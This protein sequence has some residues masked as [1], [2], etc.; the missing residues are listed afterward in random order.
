MA[1]QSYIMQ[2]PASAVRQMIFDYTIKSFWSKGEEVIY[3]SQKKYI[4]QFFWCL[5]LVKWNAL[6]TSWYLL[7]PGF[8]VQVLNTLL[9]ALCSSIFEGIILSSNLCHSIND[10]IRVIDLNKICAREKSANIMWVD[11]NGLYI[12]KQFF[13]CVK[14]F[15]TILKWR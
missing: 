8:S 12:L 11:R 3:W 4:L 10:Q 2:K 5:Q 9:K 7:Q 14:H 6:K 1:S 13:S 15:K